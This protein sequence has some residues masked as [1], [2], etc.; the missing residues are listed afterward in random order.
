MNGQNSSYSMSKKSKKRNR[1]MNTPS[2]DNVLKKDWIVHNKVDGITSVIKY[3]S[4]N[5]DGNYTIAVSRAIK[6]VDDN[7][8]S[9]PQG[10]LHAL[11]RMYEF[12]HKKYLKKAR[13]RR[14]DFIV[15]AKIRRIPGKRVHSNVTIFAVGGEHLL[16][17]HELEVWHA[18]I[19]PR[20][21][22]EL[23]IIQGDF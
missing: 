4:R 14:K 18:V 8:F 20:V 17:I 15:E 2:M 11:T 21:E 13:S 12:F 10:R 16:N 6:S 19:L 23:N 22:K 9:R 1:E 7:M 5:T 3:V